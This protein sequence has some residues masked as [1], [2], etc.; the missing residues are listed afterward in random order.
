MRV[1]IV[2]GCWFQRVLPGTSIAGSLNGQGKIPVG[3]GRTGMELGSVCRSPIV[4]WEKNSES[5]G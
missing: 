5:R 1:S 3:M 2:G 4:R